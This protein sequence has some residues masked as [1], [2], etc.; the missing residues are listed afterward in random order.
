MELMTG[1]YTDN[2]PD[3]TW[4]MPYEEKTFTQYFMPYKKVGMVKNATIRAAVGMS[5][6]DGQG[7][8][9]V[10]ATQLFENAAIQISM[11]DVEIRKDTAQC[12]RTLR[13][14]RFA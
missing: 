6:R 2:Q 9:T 10:Y 13:N 14:G 5:V 11:E 12:Q 3:F 1:C 8:V 4:M 7:S